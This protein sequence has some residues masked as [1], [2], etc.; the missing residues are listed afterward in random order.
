M[1]QGLIFF[2]TPLAVLVAAGVIAAT[3]Q[4]RQAWTSAAVLALVSTVVWLVYVG[5]YPG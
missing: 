2:V 3:R 5:L 1:V 4:R